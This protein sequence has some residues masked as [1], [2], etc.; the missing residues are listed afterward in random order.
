MLSWT[1]RSDGW[2]ANDFRIALAAPHRWLLLDAD[3]DAPAVGLEEQPLAVAR[4]LAECK[5]EAE[6][7]VAKRRR[8]ILQRRQLLTVLLVIAGTPLL[9][10][11][12]SIGN[13]A[14]V[15]VALALATRSVTV[16][17]GTLMPHA[18]GEQHEVFYQ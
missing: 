14:I 2:Y 6:L 11:T 8:V 18:L 13:G 5:R 10:G 15:L 1:Q 16:L 4:S 7:L 9:L 17:L 3:R 12:S